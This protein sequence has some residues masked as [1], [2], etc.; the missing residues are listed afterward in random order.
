MQRLNPAERTSCVT[1]STKEPVQKSSTV[2]ATRPL[3]SQAARRQ[4]EAGRHLL[5]PQP[6]VVAAQEVEAS[7]PQP[8]PRFALFC[9]PA[10]RGINRTYWLERIPA[11]PWRAHG[12]RMAGH[13]RRPSESSSQRQTRTLDRRFRYFG[14][15]APAWAVRPSWSLLPPEAPIAPISLPSAMIGMPPST[16]IAPVRRRMRRPS[17]PPATVS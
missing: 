16:G 1:S 9:R 15:A 14:A 4:A 8:Q 2:T 5:L 6:E 3:I 13:Q 7:P 11:A 10:A 17:P 12:S